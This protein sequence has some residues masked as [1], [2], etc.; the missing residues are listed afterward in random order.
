MAAQQ[1]SLN[2]LKTSPNQQAKSPGKPGFW[3]HNP[4]V[5]KKI[6]KCYV[7]GCDLIGVADSKSVLLGR[8]FG[9]LASLDG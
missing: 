1:V 9:V 8:K 7:E 2:R 3:G 4:M 5:E 6:G